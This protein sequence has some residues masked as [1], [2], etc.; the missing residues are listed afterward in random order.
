MAICLSEVGFLLIMSEQK[1]LIT[2]ETTVADLL[3][4]YPGLEQRL[5]ELSPSFAKL[6]NPLLRRTVARITTLRRA[7]QVAGLMPLIWLIPYVK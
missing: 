4:Y 7:A 2:P 1:L 5:L 3:E 6:K